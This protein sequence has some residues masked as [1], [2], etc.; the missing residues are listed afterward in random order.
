MRGTPERINEALIAAD[1]L[2]DA[3]AARVAALE[4]KPA[5]DDKAKQSSR[6]E[7]V[8]ADAEAV[9]KEL[10]AEMAAVRAMAA[11]TAEQWAQNEK[12]HSHLHFTHDENNFD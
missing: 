1:K 9:T 8:S 6:S 11:A 5:D 7:Q 10:K 4:K 3:V 12:V 2:R